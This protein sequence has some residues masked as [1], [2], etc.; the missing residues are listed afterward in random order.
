MKTA[1][2]YARVSGQKQ[3]ETSIDTQIE[4]I[5]KF[6]KDAGIKIVDTFVD[7]ITAA[8]TKERPAFNTMIARALQG[9]FDIILVWKQDRF[10]RDNVEEHRILRQLEKENVYVISAMEHI[11]TKT[12]AGRLQRWMMSGINRF[13]IENLQQEIQK[14]TTKVALK[15]YFLGGVPPYG[16]KLK[17]V[18]DKEASRNRK[19]FEIDESEAPAIRKMFEMYA[20]GN[21]FGDITKALNK[22][23][24]KPRNNE[25][26]SKSSVAEM[27][28]NEKYKGTYVY[29][30]GTKHNYH[31]KR[32][33]TIRVDNA[34]PAIVTAELFEKV[35]RK[36][37]ENTTKT[38]AE[39][40]K[41]IGLLAGLAYCGDCGA[42]MYFN[43]RRSAGSCQ[44]TCGRWQKHRDVKCVQLSKSKAEVQVIGYIE[45]EMLN[46][47]ID[48]DEMA[49][50][51]NNEQAALDDVLNE[52][53]EELAKEEANCRQAID[54]A[55]KAVIEGSPIADELQKV[56]GEKREELKQLEADR[57]ALLEKGTTRITADMIKQKHEEYRKMLKS[58]EKEKQ[59]LIRL[60]IEKVIIFND[61][62]VKVYP[63]DL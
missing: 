28:K 35:K 4:D 30:K 36:R 52:K 10:H 37:S 59:Y 48:Y 5:Q 40:V 61:G 11:D 1:A 13:Y 47:D 46:A 41:Q 60:L 3:S 54:N 53:L 22:L 24:F 16:Y 51:Y 18:R 12:P 34:I 9:D 42:K 44:Y 58:N 57:K 8:G 29:R 55:V 23:P 45:L 62:Y 49:E 19:I 56:A 27:L 32:T 63:K 15:A 7:K 20:A 31:A 14:K 33:D 50:L 21:G 25:S 43:S 38:Q 2:A 17:E 6:A 26:W 39:G